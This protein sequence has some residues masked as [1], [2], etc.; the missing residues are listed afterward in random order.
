M[1]RQLE[2]ERRVA[3]FVFAEA[4]AI[5]PD[6]GGG[7]DSFEVDKDPVAARFREAA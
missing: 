3:A 2:G 5:D 6:R 7:H 1:R 4:L